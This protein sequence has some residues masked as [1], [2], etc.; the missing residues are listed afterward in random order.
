MILLIFAK[1]LLLTGFA[2]SFEHKHLQCVGKGPSPIPSLQAQGHDE[3]RK[4]F[5]LPLPFFVLPE[6]TFN[7]HVFANI[8]QR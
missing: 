5:S 4:V 3:R 6:V 1:V 2:V 7:T 8:S